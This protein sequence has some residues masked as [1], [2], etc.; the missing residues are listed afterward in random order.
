MLPWDVWGMMPGP[1]A[2]IS[3][4]DRTFLDQIAALTL[5]SY[6]TIGALQEI[7]DDPCVKVSRKVF[8]A[9]RKIEEELT[10]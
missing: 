9:D 1:T 5:G 10:F 6:D 8:N 3:D 2:T 4:D 7:Y